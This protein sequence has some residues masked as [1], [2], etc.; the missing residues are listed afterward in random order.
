ML[1]HV[2]AEGLSFLLCSALLCSFRNGGGLLNCGFR[3]H[4]RTYGTDGWHR[5]Q[6][7]SMM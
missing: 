6:R 4:S 7:S 1:A 3:S 2:G 5:G